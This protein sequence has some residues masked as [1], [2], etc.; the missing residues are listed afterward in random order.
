MVEIHAP[1]SVVFDL[2]ARVERWPHLLPH[3]RSVR[4]LD[5]QAHRRVVEMAASR[6]GLPIRW[7]AVQELR[8]H[9][10]RITFRHIGGITRGMEVQW[11]I[12]PHGPGVLVR[13]WHGFRPG[14]PLVPDALIGLVVGKLFVHNIASKTLRCLKALA[15]ARAAAGGEQAREGP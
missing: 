7:R 1:A 9:E 11:T 15:E 6:D 14:W 3:Y 12:A 10:G 8:P 13:I 5:D 4:V 2:A